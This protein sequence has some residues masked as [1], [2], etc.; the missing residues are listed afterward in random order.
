[1]QPGLRRVTPA[2][3]DFVIDL[4]ED[5][6]NYYMAEGDDENDFSKDIAG[7]QADFPKYRKSGVAIVVASLFP[8]IRTWNPQLQ[9][10]LTAGYGAFSA[11]QVA[12]GPTAIALEQMK[13]YYKMRKRF[14]DSFRIVQRTV[15]LEESVK[16]PR[17]GFLVCL[18]GTEAL[19]DVSDLEILYKLGV[20]AVG[21]TWNFDTRFA[22]SCMSK[23]DYGLTG[24]GE[25]LV[26]EANE[27][28][29]IVDL[30]HSSKATMLD[31][32]ALS[33]CPVM[34]SHANYS[35]VHAH[36]RNVN[37]DVLEPLNQNGG[38]IGFTLINDT[39]GPNPG[40]DSLAKHIISVRERYGSD[41]LAIGTDYLGITRPP[42]G[43]E[44]ITKLENL[45]H[46]LAELGMKDDEL[47]KLAWQNA[48][49]MINQNAHGWP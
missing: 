48:Y 17:V 24:E 25:H 19:E 14:P 38:V 1:M 2:M 3:S 46:K 18:E 39:I 10:H 30:A 26:E 35:Q 28:G 13:I 7:R 20:R 36:T 29:V 40:I 34:I 11:A 21:L 5:V 16:T 32:L 33:N 27:M 31:V 12:K 49:R 44:D 22:A 15:D 41:I 23:K 45:L 43:L 9:A 4:H 8:L 42:T 47:R 6:A 37:D